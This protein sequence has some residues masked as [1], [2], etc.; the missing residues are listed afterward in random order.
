M[1][2]EN[3]LAIEDEI[4]QLRFKKKPIYSS[5]LLRY[6]L[7]LRYTSMQSYKLLQEEF[8]MP[9][10]S[11]LKKLT[12]GSLDTVKAAKLLQQSGSISQDVILMFD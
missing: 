11:L 1:A 2:E 6:A 7:T 3:G 5:S 4:H 10:V 8:N 9:S 12:H